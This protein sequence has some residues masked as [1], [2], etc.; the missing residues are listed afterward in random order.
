MATLA[1]PWECCLTLVAM[2]LEP[3]PMEFSSVANGGRISL[4]VDLITFDPAHDS[5]LLQVKHSGMLCFYTGLLEASFNTTRFVTQCWDVS[6]LCL[7][8]FV[9]KQQESFR[10]HAVDGMILGKSLM[11]ALALEGLHMGLWPWV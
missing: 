6:I 5:H 11:L 2:A 8:S 3:F 7:G 1:N 9:E 10:M 4:V